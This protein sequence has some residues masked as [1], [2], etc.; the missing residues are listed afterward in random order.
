MADL[1]KRIMRRVYF[2]WFMRQ[3]FNRVTAK[4]ALVL[5]F[6]WQ[7]VQY[8]SV[9]DVI[10]NWHPADWGISGSY[11]FFESALRNTE[12]T[13]QIL[14]LGMAVVLALLVRDAI[15]KRGLEDSRMF[16]GI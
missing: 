7:F 1:T 16:V 15:Q 2:V 12:F 5:L 11:A 3:I 4:L 10:S 13:V 14:M 6:I 8:V 9:R